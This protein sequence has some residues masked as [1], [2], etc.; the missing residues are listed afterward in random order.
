M[1]CKALARTAALTL[2]SVRVAMTAIV[3]VVVVAVVVL[4][5]TQDLYRMVA[6]FQPVTQ[7][8]I[9]PDILI[10]FQLKNLLAMQVPPAGENLGSM[11][12]FLIN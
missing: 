2:G 3:V 6:E 11:A 5:R 12:P 4:I 7:M 1:L 8:V 10:A 9:A